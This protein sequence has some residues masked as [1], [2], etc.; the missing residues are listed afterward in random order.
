MQL[1]PADTTALQVRVQ[2]MAGLLLTAGRQVCP[3]VVVKVSVK[4]RF[5]LAYTQL[6]RLKATLTVAAA[7][8]RV[9]SLLSVAEAV[10]AGL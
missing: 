10:T 5:I 9:D 6:S 1:Q 2:A 7:V 4:N 3:V 8:L